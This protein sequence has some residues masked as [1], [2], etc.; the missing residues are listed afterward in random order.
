MCTLTLN[1]PELQKAKENI[2]VYKIV[3]LEEHKFWFIKRRK[4]YSC[5]RQFKYIRYKTY[6][7]YLDCFKRKG[8]SNLYYSERGFYSYYFKPYIKYPEIIAK[9][10]IP[11]NSYYYLCRDNISKE[12]IYTSDKIKIVKILDV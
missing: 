8:N 5:I 11:K 4:I 9:C 6:K 1:K 10:I 7:T 2:I 3:L 12:W